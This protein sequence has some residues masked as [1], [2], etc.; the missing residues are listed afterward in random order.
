MEMASAKSL[1]LPTTS[2]AWSTPPPLTCCTAA[3]ASKSSLSANRKSVAPNSVAIR[4]LEGARSIAM[5]WEAPLSR[6][7]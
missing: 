6:A 4:S 2:K 1:V 3:T 7:A 5:T